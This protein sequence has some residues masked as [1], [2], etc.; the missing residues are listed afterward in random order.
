MLNVDSIKKGIVID[1]IEKGMGIKIYNF[2]KLNEV[3]GS[4]ALLMNV[5]SEKQGRK[6]IIKIENLSGID[7]TVL[8]L[9][10][11]NITVNVIEDE[12]IKEKIKLKL[13]DK[14]ANIIKCKNPRCITSTEDY[15]PHEFYLADRQKGEYRCKYYDESYTDR[16]SVV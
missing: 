13:P 15:V 10:D 16:K 5:P 8:G 2:L 1:H 7:F 14:V 4:V 12:K 9:I 11:S 3:E 6:D